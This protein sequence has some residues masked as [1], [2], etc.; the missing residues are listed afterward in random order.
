MKK[1]EAIVITI[2]DELLIGQVLDTNTAY[3]AQ[4]LN[5]LGV[6]LRRHI[7]VG[8]HADDIWNALV[9]AEQD[10]DII[11]ITGGLGPTSDDITK[12]LLNKYFN[13]NLKIHMPTLK[14]IEHL[15]AA[16]GSLVTERNY[17]QAQVPD[18]CEV[19][20]NEKGTAPGMLF[21]KNGHIF[22]SMPG[23][24]HE[25]QYIM[26][27]HV[28]PLLKRKF[29]LPDISHK[30]ISTLGISE[31]VLADR[32]LPFE[33]QLPATIRLAYLPEFGSIKLRLTSR[34]ENKNL[35]TDNLN[36]YF[37]LLK[38]IIKDVVFMDNDDSIEGWISERL[39]ESKQTLAIAESCTGGAIADTFV[40]QAGASQFFKGSIVS[41]TTDIKENLLHINADMITQFGVV[42]REVVTQM[43]DNVRYIMDSDYSIATSGVFGPGSQ[44][45][46]PSGTIWI[47][48]ANSKE[49]VTKVLNLPYDR[50]VNKNV[51]IKYALKLLKDLIQSN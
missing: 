31:S 5:S 19:L 20:S 22:I 42:S 50:T 16:R 26:Q 18:T 4:Q 37:T 35:K 9:A 25:M 8:D 14:H 1:I 41:Y 40:N 39:I 34:G 28:L 7:C 36:Y 11:L 32:L 23:V 49:I 27:K 21:E 51:T 29:E 46:I 6:W 44:D 30:N 43:V 47:A 17:R 12:P 48:V 45:N 2:G 10:A 24:P 3:M 38:D 15:F 13:G 33:K